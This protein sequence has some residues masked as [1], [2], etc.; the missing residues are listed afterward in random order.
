[1][2]TEDSSRDIFL[3]LATGN[4]SCQSSTTLRSDLAKAIYFQL[5]YLAASASKA[6]RTRVIVRLLSL[7]SLRFTA[8]EGRQVYNGCER[9]RTSNSYIQHH[10]A[11][12]RQPYKH[13]A[14]GNQCRYLNHILIC[15]AS[16]SPL[17]L[18]S[19]EIALYDRQIRL[20]G[21]KAQ[22]KIRNANVLLVT[23]KA[24]GNEIAKNLALAG[25]GSLT[26]HDN[27]HVT[28]DDLCSQFFLQESDIGRFVRPEPQTFITMT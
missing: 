3:L 11:K 5:S 16:T 22:Q 25:V 21:M 7:P 20:W 27:A 8:A 23:V 26:L 13:T 9:Q 1:L 15:P 17:T 10:H 6:E 28:D 18:I 14:R 2:K 24:L 12:F 4:Q 19:D